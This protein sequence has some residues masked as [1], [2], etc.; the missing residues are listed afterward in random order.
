MP[1][2]ALVTA[3]TNPKNRRA[4]LAGAQ[5]PAT[6]Q[7]AR[8]VMYE[9][10]IRDAEDL[11]A[12]SL[13]EAAAALAEIAS[14]RAVEHLVNHKTG[15]VHVVPVNPNTRRQAA[16]DIL[17]RMAGKPV[18]TTELK[19]SDAQRGPVFNILLGEAAAVHLAEQLGQVER[20]A[21]AIPALAA[22]TD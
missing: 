11:L 8:Y 3:N 5:E 2:R 13:L 22:S 18:N 7:A 21:A 6:S 20:E 9:G 17:N 19:V 16:V 4:V 14:G 10:E 12:G 15:E 1:R